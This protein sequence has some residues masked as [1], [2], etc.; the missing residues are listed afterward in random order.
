[1]NFL[2]DSGSKHAHA[3]N[4]SIHM[5]LFLY[6]GLVYMTTVKQTHNAHHTGHV[7]LARHGQCMKIRYQINT[8]PC[9]RPMPSWGWNSMTCLF[10]SKKTPTYPRN[11]DHYP[12]VYIFSGIRNH[13][14]TLRYLGYVP[15]VCWNFLRSFTHLKSLRSESLG[16]QRWGCLWETLSPQNKT[17]R[18]QYSL[19]ER[20]KEINLYVFLG[21]KYSNLESG[22][23]KHL[24]FNGHDDLF[25]G[26]RPYVQRLD[27]G[28]VDHT[29]PV[30]SGSGLGDTSQYPRTRYRKAPVDT[31][32]KVERLEGGGNLPKHGRT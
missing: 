29:P 6:L 23:L 18:P 26:P 21:Y 25:L 30:G 15:G 10:L 4:P 8:Q 20:Q 27:V 17:H 11:T 2:Y 12:P 3:S 24:T 13:I 19:R 14:G 7:M 28:G 5:L 22:C 31:N 16:V 32:A 9:T 1:M